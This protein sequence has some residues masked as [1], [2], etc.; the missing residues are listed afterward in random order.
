MSWADLRLTLNQDTA[1]KKMMFNAIFGEDL[2]QLIISAYKPTS[3]LGY[4]AARDIMYSEIDNNSGGEI[5][6]DLENEKI[7]YLPQKNDLLIF[8]STVHHSVNPYFGNNDRIAIAWDAIY[9]F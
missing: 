6:L 3:T 4:N 2:K 8:N 1:F 5:N 7:T 9:T